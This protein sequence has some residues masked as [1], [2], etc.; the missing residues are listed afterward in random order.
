MKYRSIVR[1]PFESLAKAFLRRSGVDEKELRTNKPKNPAAIEEYKQAFCYFA[2]FYTEATMEEIGTYLGGYYQKT[3]LQHIEMAEGA[4]MV[5][6]S[7]RE[8]ME[9][10]H[11]FHGKITVP[12][13]QLVQL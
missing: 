5:D 11:P 7:Y 10:I 12:K 8:W 4:L 2:H 1:H 9:Q 13:K 6:G 3:I